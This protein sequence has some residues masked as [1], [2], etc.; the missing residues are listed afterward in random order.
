MKYT[1]EVR[2]HP[3]GNFTL[4]EQPEDSSIPKDSYKINDDKQLFCNSDPA[5]FYRATAKRLFEISSQGHIIAHFVDT[6]FPK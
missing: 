2:Y 4:M 1:I 6:Q 5:S 3:I